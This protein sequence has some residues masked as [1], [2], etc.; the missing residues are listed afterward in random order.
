MQD[1]VSA[2]FFHAMFR[3]GS[4]YMFNKFRQPELGYWCYYEPLHEILIH[5]LEN[6]D[7][8]LEIHD[9]DRINLRHPELDNPYF[10]E[11]HEMSDAIGASFHKSFSYD[12]YFFP[13]G[14]DNSELNVYL[15]TLIENAQGRPFLQCCR[16]MGRITRLKREHGGIHIY[17]WRN[18]WDQ[19]WSYKKGF[20]TYNLLILNAENLPKFLYELKNEL[21][22]P[23]FHDSDI[24]VEHAHFHKPWLSASG[25]YQLFYALWCHGMLEAMPCCDLSI[26]IDMLSSSN[27]Y[28]CKIQ[29]E[30]EK[31][32]LNVPDFSDCHIPL[33]IYGLNDK[34]FFQQAETHIHDLLLSNGY[35]QEKISVLKALA[36]ARYAKVLNREKEP[37]FRDLVRTR[38]YL[39]EAENTLANYYSEIIIYNTKTVQLQSELDN[40]NSK[41]DVLNTKTVQL[42]SEL[43]NSNSKVDVLNTKTV[44]LQSELD[45]SKKKTNALNQELK[46]VYDSKSWIITW[47]LRKL[48]QFVQWI[49][50][51][52]IKLTLWLIR[53]PK[54]IVRWVLVK[55]MGF[56]LNHLGL[57]IRIAAIIKRYPRVYNKIRA[58]ALAR[59]LLVTAQETTTNTIEVSNKHEEDS[60]QEVE[61]LLKAPVN[62]VTPVVA[63]NEPRQEGA[64][65]GFMEYASQWNLGAR[66]DV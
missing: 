8:L 19:W 21:H 61:D 48:S 62:E 63:S 22:T 34:V 36:D 26:Q 35:S 25:S 50:C 3:T 59:G 20:D 66:K 29:C 9:K 51:L 28:R 1:D 18:P 15:K 38:E 27:T 52:P 57:R 33:A 41:V 43:D 53:L 23:D 12:D 40:S 24:Y 37:V 32:G 58:L 5:T 49:F 56:V 11:F 7:K 44:Q 16:S 4:T 10:Y 47:P 64:Q 65:M 13:D 6:P 14:L 2:V 17:L 31:L 55:A 39:L 30:M 46:T 45:N 42:Q 60:L 54:R